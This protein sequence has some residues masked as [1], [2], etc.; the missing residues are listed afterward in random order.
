MPAPFEFKEWAFFVPLPLCK[1]EVEIELY[2]TFY[3]PC[4]Y[5]AEDYG[6]IPSVAVAKQI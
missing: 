1:M 2:N 6:L 3:F 4:F 5:F